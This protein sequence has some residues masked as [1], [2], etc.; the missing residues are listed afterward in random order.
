MLSNRGSTKASLM[1]IFF[2]VFLACIIF[3]LIAFSGKLFF[4]SSNSYESEFENATEK[5][6]KDYYGDLLEGE[7]LIVR[8]LTLENLDY[9][10]L[11]NCRGYSI[12]TKE[13]KLDIKAYLKCDNYESKNYDINNE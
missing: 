11:D 7:S 4:N 6:L 5:Y 1:I 12:A 13:K 3:C 2:F 9:L 8:L 10:K